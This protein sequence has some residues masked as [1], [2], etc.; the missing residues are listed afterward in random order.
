MLGVSR[1]WIVSSLVSC[2]RGTTV[3]KKVILRLL[4]RGRDIKTRGLRRRALAA[5][6]LPAVLNIPSYL[7]HACTI[8]FAG[9][10]DHGALRRASAQIMKTRKG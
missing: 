4:T 7:R 8:N 1:F 2:R 10:L 3:I 5:K 6:Y 9:S